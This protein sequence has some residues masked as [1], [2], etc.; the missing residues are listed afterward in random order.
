MQ[1]NAFFPTCDIGKRGPRHCSLHLDS[2][3]ALRIVPEAR[4]RHDAGMTT[5]RMKTRN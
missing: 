2:R 3:S 5:Q 4:L 1:L